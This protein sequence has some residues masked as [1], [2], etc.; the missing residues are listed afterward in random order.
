MTVK[1]LRKQLAAAI[2]MTLVATVALGSSTYAWFAIN[3]NVTATGMNVTAQ[4]QNNLFIAPIDVDA[5]SLPRDATFT[6]ITS[7]TTATGVLEPV[8]TINGTN[9]FYSLTD[10][11]KGDGSVNDETIA[12]VAYNHADTTPAGEYKNEFS[13]N[14]MVS[15]AN[16]AVGYVDYV[17]AL[18]AVNTAAVAADINL[19]QLFLT[20]DFNAGTADTSAFAHRVAVLAEKWNGS[21]FDTKNLVTILA[22]NGA[23]NFTDASA[24]KEAAARN[25]AGTIAEVTNPG[26]DAK[27]LADANAT[28]YYRVIVRLWIEGEDESCNNTTF[29]NLTNSWKL[30][31]RFELATGAPVNA[32]TKGVYATDG[33]DTYIRTGTEGSY[34]YY[35]MG[36][37]MTQITDSSELSTA[38]G[39]FTTP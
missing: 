13:K 24:V 26:A 22:P 36:S 18:K 32:V 20:Y 27:L 15:G 6:T 2:A 30:D 5:T 1:S 8:S 37:D 3:S 31:L 19:T 4:V 11:V 21:G 23:D 14:Y 34:K 28:T 25:A 29:Q 17:F 9:Y 35:K 33:I 16:G 12:Y 7:Q 10:N 38:Q 39:A